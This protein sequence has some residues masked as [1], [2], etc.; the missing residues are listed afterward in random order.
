[1]I[2]HTF[3]DFISMITHTFRELLPN[4]S[5]HIFRVYIKHYWLFQ[6]VTPK[7]YYTH[8]Q[9]SN[10]NDIFK[11]LLADNTITFPEFILSNTDIFREFLPN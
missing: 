2:L 1:M 5:K 8:F 7:Q 9:T 4:K 11:E 6:G 3:S 10:I